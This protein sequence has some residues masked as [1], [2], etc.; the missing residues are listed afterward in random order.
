MKKIKR[1]SVTLTVKSLVKCEQRRRKVLAR[2]NIRVS[3]DSTEVDNPNFR[4]TE[5]KFQANGSN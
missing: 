5:I 2:E 4:K 1:I 3:G